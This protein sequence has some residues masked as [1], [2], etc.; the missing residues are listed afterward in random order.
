MATTPDMTAQWEATLTDISERKSNYQNFITPLTAT[1]K[2]MVVE[3]GQQSFDQL[4][5]IPFKRKAKRKPRFKKA[6]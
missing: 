4:P 3:A 5:K 6:G 2:S 1:L